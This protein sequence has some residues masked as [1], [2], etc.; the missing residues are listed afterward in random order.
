M[1]S[2]YQSVP[3]SDTPENPY[4]TVHPHAAPRYAALPHN[5][6]QDTLLA[7][8]PLDGKLEHE[9]TGDNDGD[10]DEKRASRRPLSPRRV[11]DWEDKVILVLKATAAALAALS[12]LYVAC[13]FVDGSADGSRAGWN[14]LPWSDS[15]HSHHHHRPAVDQ[16]AISVDG[17]PVASMQGDGIMFGL[18]VGDITGPI[19]EV[20][21]MGYASMP[22]TNTGLHIRLRSRA[23]AVGSR[24][25]QL[26]LGAA[27]GKS[28]HQLI[29][30]AD[31]SPSRWIF[32]NSDICMGDTAV[33]RGV[34]DRLRELYPGLYGERNI[35]FVGT[36]SHAGPGGFITA[37]LPT[38]TSKGVVKQN[39]DAI[40]E[41][42][43][44]AAIRAN[45]DFEQRLYNGKRTRLS[46]GRKRLPEAHIQ[47]SRYAYE[48][49]PQEERDR[50]GG[51]D[52][53]H[54]FSLLKFEELASEGGE[55]EAREQAEAK[56]FLSWYAVHG[57]SLYEN[58][59]LTSAD[60]K[61][62]AA[63]LYETAQEPDRMPGQT[64]FVAGFSQSTV[65]DTSPNTQGAWCDDGSVCE[66]KHSTC[67]NGHGKDRVQ[68]CHGRG[69]A[70]GDASLLEV[71]PTGSWDFASNEIIARMQVD[72]A[73]DIMSRPASAGGGDG[74]G[75]GDEYSSL[76]LI[77]E[78]GPVKSVKMNVDMSRYTV[79]RKDGSRVKTC[80]AALGYGF[81][82]GTTDGPGA[83]DFVQGSN[84]TDHHNAFWDVVKAFIKSPT[85]EQ[86][87]CQAPKS[88]LL[89]VG[90]IHR[91]YD[92]GPSIVEVQMLRVGQLF[93]LVVP[94]E[95]TTMAG[96]RLKAAVAASISEAG[97]LPEGVEP[98]L[99][100]S[101]PA[102]TY[103]HY[104]TTEEEYSVQRY[105][106]ASTLFGPHTLEAYL[107][108]FA[109]RLVPAL[110]EDARDLPQGPWK[111]VDLNKSYQLKTGVVYD[112]APLGHKFGD[113]LT[114][115]LLSYPVPAP[116]AAAVAGRGRDALVQGA[117]APRWRNASLAIFEDGPVRS[118]ASNV[119]AVFVAANP[120][121][122]LRLE[123]TYFEVQRYADHGE[124]RTVRTDGHHS[125]TLRWKRTNGLTGSS[126]V[127]VS[128]SIESWTE[129]GLYRIVYNGDR[130]M[131]FTGKVSEFM[132][133]TSEFYVV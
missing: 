64:T 104:I 32:I 63:L 78:G 84:T 12:L 120:R 116:S 6:S 59:T 1:P 86:K 61:G 27:A 50:Y 3:Q 58:N 114:Q 121:N 34:V 81:A 70:W 132:A 115:P 129:P 11:E 73:R 52:L 38:L 72:A 102:S 22:Q 15:F 66:Y 26:D 53:D 87:E 36:H 2:A 97:L 123:G 69:P 17:T 75:D 92:W 91:P 111:Q 18:G 106:G 24:Q 98:I 37:L 46:F 133:I 28:P 57:T 107:D 89:D 60:N 29:A 85:E 44:Q 9:E 33:R 117:A 128:W 41:G 43:V 112:N 25:R 109:R 113:V 82:G 95:F 39:V 122:N 90:E 119:T 20:N 30:T 47:R 130:K 105:E 13:C 65:G 124:W 45:D 10:N 35:A 118:Q 76:T 100:I 55:G 103:G 125:T 83:F 8:S 31:G 94:G 16:Q 77:D 93:I 49:N 14:L 74:D 71:S 108:V 67:D 80:P 4:A 40:I 79:Y 48:Q 56:G 62:L 101:G 131:P 51:D 42:T 110:K 127:E 21:M 126:T 96:R 7:E 54:D 99:Q 23:F 5:D 19:V 88:V 68:T